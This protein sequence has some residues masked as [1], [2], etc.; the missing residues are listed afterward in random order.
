MSTKIKAKQAVYTDAERKK[1]LPEGHADAAYL[2]VG[3]GCEIH[4]HELEKV[5]GAPELAA[6]AVKKAPEPVPDAQMVDGEVVTPKAGNK[7]PKAAAKA[8]KAATKAKK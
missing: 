5:D 3:E 4:E 8:K 6:K 7:T 1:A 2:L